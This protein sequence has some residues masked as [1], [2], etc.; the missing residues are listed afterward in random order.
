MKRIIFILIIFAFTQANHTKASETPSTLAQS[1]RD[2]NIVSMGYD[3]MF[4]NADKTD[5]LLH[6]FN[7]QLVHGFKL[8]RK[9]PLYLETGI[10]LTYN[11]GKYI[12]EMNYEVQYNMDGS[13]LSDNLITSKR[14]TNSL[15][16]YLPLSLGYRF[17]TSSSFSI[18]PYTGFTVSINP[19]FDYSFISKSTIE[20]FGT[21]ISSLVSGDATTELG[22]LRWQVGIKFMISKILLGAQYNLDLIPLASVKSKVTSYGI[23]DIAYKDALRTANLSLSIGYIF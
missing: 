22:N 2:Y 4:L 8:D 18:L 13:I 11:T 10:G 17:I 5:D 20:G 16:I 3:L 19:R 7:L 6:G 14:G 23:P 1:A 12:H 9:I 15:R 21:T